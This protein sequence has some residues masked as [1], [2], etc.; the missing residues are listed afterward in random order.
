MGC[1]SPDYYSLRK[2]W[3]SL[4]ENFGNSS[5]LKILTS[6]ILQSASNDPEMNSNALTWK[7]AHIS[8]PKTTKSQTITT[9]LYDQPSSRYCTF[10]GFSH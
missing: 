9:L 1:I 3:L 5:L 4:D 8:S 6:E 7:V 10:L 2:V